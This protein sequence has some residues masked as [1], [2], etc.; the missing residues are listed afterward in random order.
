MCMSS[1]SINEDFS[2]QGSIFLLLLLED[3]DA[4]H[5][6]VQ[7]LAVPYME[8]ILKTLYSSEHF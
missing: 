4:F 3:L 7:K 1:S 6:T 2:F 5:S 8:T